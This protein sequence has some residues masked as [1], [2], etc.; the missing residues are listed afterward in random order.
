[1]DGKL[2]RVVQ[3]DYVSTHRIDWDRWRLTLEC[4]HTQIRPDCKAHVK[5]AKCRECPDGR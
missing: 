4:G 2:K 1:M 5:R 3:I